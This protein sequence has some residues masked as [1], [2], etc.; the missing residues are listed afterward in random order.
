VYVL[1]L[2]PIIQQGHQLL[3]QNQHSGNGELTTS[4]PIS[5]PFNAPVT[6]IPDD[7]TARLTYALSD[8]SESVAQGAFDT[9]LTT[10][11]PRFITVFIELMR[12][13]QIDLLRGIG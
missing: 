11:E 5:L 4:F 13:N 8:S 3:Q 2:N 12:A 10:N 9:F 1:Y 7:D 6:P